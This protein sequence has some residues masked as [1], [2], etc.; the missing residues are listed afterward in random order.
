[1]KRELETR[2]VKVEDDEKEMLVKKKELDQLKNEENLLQSK[3]N[4]CK[5]EVENLSSNVGQTQLQISQVKTQLVSLEEY[6]H[7]LTEGSKE[8]TAAMASKDFHNLTKLLARPLTPPPELEPEIASGGFDSDP[9]KNANVSNQLSTDPFAGE[10]P[11][12]GGNIY[13]DNT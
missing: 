3:L 8:L 7:H 6:E 12:K 11:F 9:F 2:K 4:T 13:D 10:D 1:M 5:K